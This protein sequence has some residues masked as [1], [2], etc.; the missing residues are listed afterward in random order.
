MEYNPDVPAS[1][2]LEGQMDEPALVQA[3]REDPALFGELYRRNVQRVYRY[4]YSRIGNVHE[5]EDLTAQTFMAAF[6]SFAR[7]RRA[8]HFT[9]WLFAIARHKAMDHFRAGKPT[10]PVEALDQVPFNENALDDIAQAEQVQALN[11][12]LRKLPDKDQE[13]LRLRFLAEMSFPDMART[14]HRSEAATK[15]AFYRLLEKLH[16]QL[17]ALNE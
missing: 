10:V 2:Q 6:E 15:K 9:S 8:D 11:G 16:N 7:L 17:E 4:L 3:A 14:L 12:M 13:M 5:A 1:E